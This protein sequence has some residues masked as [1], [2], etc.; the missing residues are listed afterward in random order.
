MTIMDKEVFIVQPFI[1][2]PPQN[3]IL[4][5]FD[6]TKFQI[7][8]KPKKIYHR[9]RQVH[10][11]LINLKLINKIGGYYDADFSPFIFEDDDLVL[12]AL[13]KGYDI[14]STNKSVVIHYGGVTRPIPLKFYILIH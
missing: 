10:P 2:Q 11:Y 12:R 9:C 1:Y 5:S 3:E 4:K 7:Y 14:K 6:C 13:K 8:N